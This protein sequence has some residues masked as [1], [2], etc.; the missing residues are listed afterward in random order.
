MDYLKLDPQILVGIINTKLRNNYS[1]IDELCSDL[2]INKAELIQKLGKEDYRYDKQNNQFK[3][4][5]CLP[6][7][8]SFSYLYKALVKIE[9][10]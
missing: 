1:S 4:K 10:E 5:G 2:N 7:Q 6:R 9:L 3:W 8:A